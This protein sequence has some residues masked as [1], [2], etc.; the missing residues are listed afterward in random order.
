MTQFLGKILEVNADTREQL[1]TFLGRC[2]P[3]ATLFMRRAFDNI[4]DFGGWWLGVCPADGGPLEGVSCVEGGFATM[5]ATTTSA[6]IALGT[7]LARE[8]RVARD[9]REHHIVGTRKV[10]HSFYDEFKVIDREVVHDH[11]RR[12]MGTSETCAAFESPRIGVDF[13]TPADDPVLFEFL[14]E[15]QLEQFGRDPR[16]NRDGH[17]RFCAAMRDAGRVVVGRQGN[18]PFMVAELIPFPGYTLIERLYFPRPFRRSKLMARGLATT[19]AIALQ[20]GEEVLFFADAHRG[21]QFEIADMVGFVSRE[22]YRHLV[23]R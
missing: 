15:Q 1:A 11:E 17:S 6:A 8:S 3:H 19:L 9:N 2:S 7:H 18:T 12:L 21:Y 14:G 16:R 23:L 5:H 13:A 10:I 20:S 4:D 22:T